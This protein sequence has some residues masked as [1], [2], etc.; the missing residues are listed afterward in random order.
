MSQVRRLGE[1]QEV[2]NSKGGTST[3]FQGTWPATLGTDTSFNLT[4]RKEVAPARGRK[5]SLS[6]Q[7]PGIVCLP[8]PWPGR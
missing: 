8:E 5:R 7:L 4:C 6:P 1:K 3:F 2:N